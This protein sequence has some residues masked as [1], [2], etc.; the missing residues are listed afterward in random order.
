MTG[1]HVVDPL[2]LQYLLPDVHLNLHLGV[3]K[4]LQVELG[5][6]QGDPALRAGGSR[7]DEHSVH[8]GVTAVQEERGLGCSSVSCTLC[9]SSGAC[10]TQNSAHQEAAPGLRLWLASAHTR[11]HLLT[12]CAHTQC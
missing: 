3:L 4:L 6:A 10:L 2:L 11:P 7:V 5:L 8:T 12:V 1:T 9:I